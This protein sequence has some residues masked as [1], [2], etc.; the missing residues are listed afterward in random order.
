MPAQKPRGVEAR[1]VHQVLDLGTR[2]VPDAVSSSEEPQTELALLTDARPAAP[3]SETDV[4]AS[5]LQQGFSSK[6]H[7]ET[8]GGLVTGSGCEIDGI[9]AEIIGRQVGR[10]G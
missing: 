7:V 8:A 10:E 6:G 4:E 1:R 9:V 5:D 2:I 3:G